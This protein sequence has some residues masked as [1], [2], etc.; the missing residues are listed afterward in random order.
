MEA[1]LEMELEI[2]KK[3]MI[4]AVKMMTVIDIIFTEG[5]EGEEDCYHARVQEMG[6]VCI[7]S[8]E[9]EAQALA[10]E[11]IEFFLNSNNSFMK[12]KLNILPSATLK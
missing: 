2:E 6:I 9:E 4:E 11:E 7:S 8:S 3:L 12:R 1:I 10:E 5:E